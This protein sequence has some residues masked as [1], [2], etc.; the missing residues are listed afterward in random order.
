MIYP[1]E[2]GKAGEL[3][4]LKTLESVWI[5]GRLKM[6]GRWSFIGEGRI[7]NSFNQLLA[8]KKLTKTA[9][10]EALRRMKKSGI[11]KPEL[12]AFLKEMLE[13][14]NKSYLT[15]CSDNEALIIDHVVGEVLAGNQKLIQVLHDRYDGRGKS[16]R[17]M[18]EEL[19][20]KNPK[21]SLATCRRR[22]DT[23]LSVAEFMLYIPMRDAFRTNSH[24]EALNYEPDN[25]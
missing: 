11:T 25:A 12:E 8:T 10:N 16:K 17:R 1:A 18:A 2:V 3:V 23:W 7:G 19:Q 14:K 5:Q 24:K 15:H 6:W 21:L 9:I 13:G 4:R 22:I 20:E